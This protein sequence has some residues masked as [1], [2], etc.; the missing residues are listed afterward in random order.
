MGGRSQKRGGANAKHLH[1]SLC[2]PGPLHGRLLLLQGAHP[3]PGLC[4][5]IQG[6]IFILLGF[7]FPSP[8]RKATRLN[9]LA[10]S[11]LFSFS[12]LTTKA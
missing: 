2:W 5:S 4:Q 6:T 3:L 12:V 7:C 1:A 8:E 9:D 11:F 10:V